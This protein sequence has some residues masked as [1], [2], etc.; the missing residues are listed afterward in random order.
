M[1]TNHEYD[2]LSELAVLGSLAKFSARA[3]PLRQR[4]CAGKIPLNLAV[5]FGL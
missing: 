1:V 4:I 5:V 3:R 2:G